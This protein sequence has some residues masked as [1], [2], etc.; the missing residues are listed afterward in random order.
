MHVKIFQRCSVRLMR[1]LLQEQEF[2]KRTLALEEAELMKQQE[3]D[4]KN[5]PKKIKEDKKR[6]LDVVNKSVSLL[7]RS[8][9]KKFLE[10]VKTLRLPR[11][12]LGGGGR[13]GWRVQLKKTQ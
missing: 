1:C 13:R 6:R 3:V 7:S 4:R 12:Y 11:T 5:V 2:T 9:R 8:E 10:Q